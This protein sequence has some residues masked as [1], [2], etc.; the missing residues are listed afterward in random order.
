MSTDIPA[1]VRISLGL[2]VPSV[3]GDWDEEES[4]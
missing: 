2:G 4:P 1:L 3:S